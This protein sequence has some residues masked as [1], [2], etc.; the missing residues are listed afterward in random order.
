MDSASEFLTGFGILLEYK[1]P[2]KKYAGLATLQPDL[3][4]FFPVV[5]TSFPEGPDGLQ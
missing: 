1:I 5:L 4:V 2:L 3:Y